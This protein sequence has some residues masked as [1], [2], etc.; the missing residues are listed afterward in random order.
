MVGK[1]NSSMEGWGVMADDIHVALRALILQNTTISAAVGTRIYNDKIPQEDL[2]E[3]Q[4]PLIAFWVSSETAL[5]A[6]DGPLG[7]D[8]PTFTIQAYDKTRPN[9]SALR[10]LIRLHIGGFA[11]VV[12]DVFIKGVAQRGGATDITDRA[13]KGSDEPRFQA[14]QNYRVSYDYALAGES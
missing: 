14:S 10:K 6:I 3:M 2:A 9:A 13:K 7:M 1:C 4:V 11:G 12:A 8:Q 5:D